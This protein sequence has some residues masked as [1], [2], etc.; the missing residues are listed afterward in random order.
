MLSK[1][2]LLSAF[3]NSMGWSMSYSLSLSARA[4]LLQ[5]NK[6]VTSISLRMNK[7]GVDGAKAFADALKVPFALNS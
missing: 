6:V 4:G 3:D 1:Y 7:I 5:E 2:P